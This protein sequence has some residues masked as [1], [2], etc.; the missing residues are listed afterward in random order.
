MRATDSKPLSLLE[1]FMMISIT[2]PNERQNLV[3]FLP[4]LEHRIFFSLLAAT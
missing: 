4:T 2:A 3:N 1:N